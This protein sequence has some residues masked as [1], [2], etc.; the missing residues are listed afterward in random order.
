MKPEQEK[1]W[2]S[3]EILDVKSMNAGYKEV[4]AAIEKTNDAHIVFKDENAEVIVAI[5][6]NFYA[7]LA[8]GSE[9]WCI[10]SVYYGG[11]PGDYF[12]DWYVGMGKAKSDR[13]QYFVWN[14]KH[15][16]DDYKLV[17]C[18]TNESLN[19]FYC[20]YN[21]PNY[22]F[23]MEYYIESVDVLKR[24][25]FFNNDNLRTNPSNV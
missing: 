2:R 17:G 24:E 25:M 21:F 23:D 4:L 11:T 22:P 9:N 5:I 15:P 16:S 19:N 8:I 6:D 1:D 10:S 18:T 3:R 14:F 12:W 20:A 7:S 13:R